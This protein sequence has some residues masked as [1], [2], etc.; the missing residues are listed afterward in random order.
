MSAPKNHHY[1]PQ[2][3]M[4]QWSA[5]GVR[6]QHID[7]SDVTKPTLLTRKTT[8]VNARRHLY[9]YENSEGRKDARLETDLY[10][11]L[12]RNAAELTRELVRILDNG[13]LPGME[14]E[15]RQLLWQFYLYNAQKRHPDTWVGAVERLDFDKI[16]KD[17]IQD[18]I[19]NGTD[20]EDARKEVDGVEIDEK[21]ETL[22]IQKARASQTAEVLDVFERIGVRFLVAPEQTSFILPDIISPRIEDGELLI[23]PI[24]PRYA[25]QPFGMNGVCERKK[26]GKAEVREINKKWYAQSKIVISDSGEQLKRLCKAIDKTTPDIPTQ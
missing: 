12:D 7:R 15:H 3:L 21:V 17:T 9:S 19:D 1:I 26:I 18:L 13:N 8:K 14:G 22:S 16:R 23:I 25:I 4:R 11:P 5:D 24:H 6:V 10:G 2:W 20:P